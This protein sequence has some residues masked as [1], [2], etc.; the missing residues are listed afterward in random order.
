MRLTEY[1]DFM[2]SEVALSKQKVKVRY[3][4][5]CPTSKDMKTREEYRNRLKNNYVRKRRMKEF[6]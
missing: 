2:N 6:T 1:L 4:H 3:S 5:F